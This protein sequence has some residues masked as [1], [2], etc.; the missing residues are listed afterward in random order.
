MTNR[1]QDFFVHQCRDVDLLCGDS[2]KGALKAGKG[3][4]VIGLYEGKFKASFNKDLGSIAL[5]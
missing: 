4:S 3:S 5:E 2:L 1:G